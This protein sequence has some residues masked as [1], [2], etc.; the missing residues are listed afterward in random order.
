MT[1]IF[2][3]RKR[4]FEIIEK[5]E[6]ND[7]ASSFYDFFMIFVII[8][9]LVPLAFKAETTA[10]M[11]ID[12]SA[13]GIFIIDYLL[14]WLTA[15]YKFNSHKAFSFI[16][17]PVSPM[18]LV[19]LVSI[20]PS[21]TLLAGGFKLL[22]VLR[23]V[24]AFRVFRVFKAMRYS[25]SFEIIGNVLKSSKNSL[26]AVCSLAAVYIVISAL[27]IFNVEPDSFNN[28]FDAVYWATVSLTTVGYGDIYP[29]STLGR[30]ITMISSVFGIAIVALPAGIITAGYMNELSKAND[31]E[32]QTDNKQEQQ[33]EEH[34]ENN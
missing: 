34:N 27:V 17:Y 12:K 23:M 22:R 26:T 5:S 30:I 7:K 16:R 21:F 24:R 13:A 29:V 19:D 32:K 3:S 33:E 15:D 2:M 18:A 6:G 11:I 10:F 14:R 9:S 31:S 28:F 8:I 4:I 25:K 20:L 1:S